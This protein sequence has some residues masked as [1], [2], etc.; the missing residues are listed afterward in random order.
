MRAGHESARDAVLAAAGPAWI[1]TLAAVQAR[2]LP[3]R[4]SSRALADQ[5]AVAPRTSGTP[6]FALHV[7]VLALLTR[8][9]EQLQPTPPG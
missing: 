6:T 3:P 5:R 4:V 7:P 9:G 1:S 2:V 8:D